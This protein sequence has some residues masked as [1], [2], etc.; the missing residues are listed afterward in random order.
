MIVKCYFIDDSEVL[1]YR[2]YRSIMF[3]GVTEMK[4]CCHNMAAYG[5]LCWQ[6]REMSGEW[7]VIYVNLGT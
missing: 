7:P 2:C 5:F 3:I 4:I 6:Q 1:F